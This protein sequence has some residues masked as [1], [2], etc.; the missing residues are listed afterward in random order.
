MYIIIVGC[1]RLGS[2]LA[3]E[4]SIGGHDISVIDHD[5]EKLS[6]L[7]S[8]FNGSRFKGVEYDNDRLL[9]AGI[10]QADYILA[11]TS[12]DNLNITVSLIAK[13]IYNV[14]RI[15]ARVGDP[16]RKYI[17][18]MLDIET[19][20]PTQLGVEIL[21][22]K[23]SEK[24]IETQSFFITTFLASTM[25]VLWLSRTGV[26]ADAVVMFRRVVYNV[27][28][29]HTTTGFG[30]VYARQFALE[31][32]DFGILILVIA[33][34]IGGSACSTAG[35]FKGLRI[36]ILFKSI[37]ADVKRLLSS[38]RNVKVFRFH[39]I[40]DQ[41]LA[42]SLVK[43]SALIVICYLITFALGTLIGT[44]CGYPLASA[45]FESASIT[46]NVGL[47]IGV[48]TADMPAFM[49]IYDIIAM[50]LGRLEF[51]SVFALIGFIIGGIKKCW[52]N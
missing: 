39:H 5:G 10:K 17:Y 12:D 23:I 2:T 36:G 15:I 43:A 34:L 46:G 51:L 16:S 52:T 27:L 21:K 37:L 48:T 31:W 35:G 1:G 18:D 26:Y 3:K 7:G 8:G 41:I 29:A 42:D 14:P 25:A 49:K 4:L 44:F 11:V 19:I 30:S 22:R 40:K 47:S 28:S 32:G 45:A 24:N 38:E 13:K 9:K 33:M 6:V 50:Y 20:C